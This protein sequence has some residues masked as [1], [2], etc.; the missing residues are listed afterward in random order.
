[1]MAGLFKLKEKHQLIGDVRG[2]GL[3]VGIELIKD[4]ES[5][6]PAT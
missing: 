4:R 6:E 2:I 5:K 3:F 1:M